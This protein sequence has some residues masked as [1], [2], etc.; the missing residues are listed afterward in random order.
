M[1]LVRLLCELYAVS[2]VD[3]QVFFQIVTWAVRV[4]CL[5]QHKFQ[6]SHQKTLFHWWVQSSKFTVMHP[7]WNRVP[8]RALPSTKKGREF[9]CGPHIGEG[10]LGPVR[11]AGCH[12]KSQ[13]YVGCAPGTGIARF[14]LLVTLFNHT[15]Q[16]IAH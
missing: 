7:A 2:V 6:R 9:Q 13:I 10:T 5:T 1:G 11:V 15:W 12:P 16:F 14:L 4:L 8:G 3:D